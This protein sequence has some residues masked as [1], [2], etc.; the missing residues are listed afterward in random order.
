MGGRVMGKFLNVKPCQ[1]S[2]DTSVEPWAVD[3][4]RFIGSNEE[5]G[6]AHLP[7]LRFA[8]MACNCDQSQITKVVRELDANSLVAEV[9]AQWRE[10][11]DYFA[12]LSNALETAINRVASVAHE[13][14]LDCRAIH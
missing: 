2:P 12:N 1:A 14:G 8:L 3:L 13:S 5:F 4:D 10:T 7:Q 11:A 6:M 9:I